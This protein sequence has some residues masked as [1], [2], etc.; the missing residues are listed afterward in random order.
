MLV[1]HTILYLFARGLPGLFAF[2]AIAIY[3]R[4]L[5]PHEYGRYSLVVAAVT[6]LNALLFQWVR[7]ALV[8]YASSAELSARLRPT[9]LALAT[10]IAAAVVIVGLPLA[11]LPVPWQPL[12]VPTLIL[13]VLTAF[14]ELFLES[15]RADMRPASYGLLLFA[16][17]AL[18]VAV[19]A[20]LALL[21]FGWWAPVIGLGVGLLVPAA[22]AYARDGAS[23]RPAFDAHTVRRVCAYGIPLSFTV[24]LVVVMGTTDRF[25]I[26]ALRGEDD[27]GL[28]A[29]GVD[30]AQFSITMLMMVVNLAAYP[31]AFRAFEKDGPDAA[32]T[33]LAQNFSLLIAVGLPAAAGMALLAG[34][35][36]HIFVGEAYRNTTAHLVPIVAVATFIAGLKSFYFDVAFQ[37][38]EKTV[39]Q[40]WVALAA[41]VANVALNAVLI[42]RFGLMGAAIASVSGWTFATMTAA[43]VGHRYFA[44]PIP[45]RPLLRVAAATAAMAAVLLPLRGMRGNVAMAIQVGAGSAAYGLVM[46]LLNFHNAR[47]R[48]LNRRSVP[49][50]AATGTPALEG[51]TC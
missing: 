21:G 6:L 9:L 43:I 26:S 20:A 27:A 39:S 51:R 30:L 2:L 37:F 15:A 46:F 12:V 8:R 32:R 47:T 42:P 13:L 38:R 3:S 40:V 17:S 14:F 16:K 29:V 44:L 24:A 28:Y 41:A 18:A 23:A 19:G 5:E 25:I 10:S 4:L 7:L 50:V 35:V 45:T 33:Q 22:V 48:F 1:R 31:L 11:A 34:N 49:S 36:A